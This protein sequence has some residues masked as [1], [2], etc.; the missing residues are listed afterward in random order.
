MVL[1]IVGALAGC[2]DDEPSVAA[3]HADA[4][5]GANDVSD[6]SG[7][8]PSG[9]AVWY[10]SVDQVVNAQ[11]ASCH[12]E[13]GAAPFALDAPEH[14]ET[15][16]MASMSAID[17]GTMPPWP[18]DADCRSYE[19]ERLLP[20]DDRELLRAW[21]DA[22][23]PVGDAANAAP[24]FELQPFEPTVAL[25][26][27][28][29]YTPDVSSQDEYRC[30][31]LDQDI[32]ETTYLTGTNVVPGSP[33]VHH[34]LAYALTGDNAA[35]ARELD[36]AEE[37]AGYTCFGGP[38]PFGVDEPGGTQS[39]SDIAERIGG[40]STFPQQIGAWVPG[41][42]P[43]VTPDSIAQVLEP[44]S[45][46]VVQIH[47]SGVAG[48]V[49]ADDGT[50]LELRFSDTAPELAR[51]TRPIA[52]RDLDIP[53]G[54]PEAVHQA[55]TPF[56][57][58]APTVVRGLTGHMHLLGTRI[59]AEVVRADEPRECALSIPEWDFDWQQSYTMRD[60]D[61][62]ELHN[63]DAIELT[64]VY[65]NS[66][67]NQPVV[68]GAQI[69]P[70][71]VQWGE[72]TLDE[73]CLLYLDIV[74]PYVPEDTSSVC[75]ASCSETCE[76][77]DAACLLA[78]SG[79]DFECV[80]CILGGV[81]ECGGTACLAPLLADRACFTQCATGSVS[82]GGDLDAC[83]TATCPEAYESFVTCVGDELLT[84]QCAVALAG[85]DL[86]PQ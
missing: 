52:I 46:I 43:S 82:L 26:I 50:R 8:A 24:A 20:A 10:G 57:G 33:L 47:Y 55:T 44:G 45:L 49:V 9:E 73:M 72:G 48:P 64:C 4:G 51:R 85:C 2:G 15:W 77:G 6:G 66:A 63:G 25:P 30:F 21:L 23:R 65:D 39:P 61:W 28:G 41:Q 13:G 81:V 58:N 14:W 62:L 3:D 71:D 1:G 84:P 11:C 19:H 38:V 75:P 35:T 18:P 32:T 22:G 86:T 36:A 7:A 74:E 27:P 34:V 69:E 31:L 17:R 79:A 68:N 56:F 54:E 29:P 78:C 42:Q 37:G 80:G 16:G 70:R 53:A 67:A 59:Q 5:G 76:A 83:M 40:L 60:G 12:T